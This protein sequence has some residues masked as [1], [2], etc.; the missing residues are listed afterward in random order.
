MQIE[1]FDEYKEY[2]NK[3]GRLPLPQ[4]NYSAKPLNERQLLTKYKDYQKKVS[5]RKVATDS[6][7]YKISDYTKR[8]MSAKQSA[9][10]N[11]PNHEVYNAFLNKLTAEQRLHL[12]KN[13]IGVF[14]IY[15]PAHI[16]DCG[17]YPYMSDVVDNI[18]MIPRY[19]HSHID[20]FL[21]PFNE[22]E[23]LT[24]DE[25]TELWKMIVGEDR[26][27]RLLE[28]INNHRGK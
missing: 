28:Q 2:Y 1:S 16:F 17:S 15:D 22:G 3:Y 26:Y 4:V 7:S 20:Q 5:G 24:A 12:K 9:R 18:V 13:S 19:L 23:H 14:G 6:E 27:N 11:D 21:D 8:V 25:H 10:D